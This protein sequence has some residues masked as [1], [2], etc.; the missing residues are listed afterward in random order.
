[1]LDTKTTKE[2]VYAI[3]EKG[4]FQLH[5]V[6]SQERAANHPKK[7]G[8]FQ[9]TF[10]VAFLSEQIL[11]DAPFLGTCQLH[12]FT[13]GFHPSRLGLYKNGISLI[14]RRDESMK[15]GGEIGARAVFEM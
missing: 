6:A 3:R 5:F 12:H 15:R 4:A 14:W 2:R 13:G 11:N 8:E 1:M 9:C 10:L 7:F